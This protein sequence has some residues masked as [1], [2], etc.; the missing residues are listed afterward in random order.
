M[1][2]KILT[3]IKWLCLSVILALG[4]QS[5]NAQIASLES[6]G[7]FTGNSVTLNNYHNTLPGVTSTRFLTSLTPAQIAASDVIYLYMPTT[8]YSAAQKTAYATHIAAGKPLVVLGDAA[9]GGSVGPINDL[10]AALGS[11]MTVNNDGLFGGCQT[12]SPATIDQNVCITSGVA[13]VDLGFASSVNPG[14]GTP[15]ISSGATVLA[16]TENNIYLFGD[17]DF[18]SGCFDSDNPIMADNI[19]FG[20][21]GPPPTGNETCATALPLNCGVSVT[22]NTV[23]VAG[24]TQGFCGTS[25]GTGGGLWYT[26]TGDGTCVELTTC[27][28]FT[29]YDTKIRVFEG[30][31]AGLICVTG[32]DDFGDCAFSFLRSRVSFEAELGV[33]YFVLVHGF[34]S[35]EGNFQLD[36]ACTPLEPLTVTCPPGENLACGTPIPA[37][38]TTEA[39]FIAAG[40]TISG[41]S[42]DPSTYTVTVM[43]VL[44]GNACAGLTMTRTY[45]VTNDNSGQSETCIQVIN[46]AAPGAPSIV[47]PADIIV[48]CEDEI[49]LDP[50]DAVVTTSCGLGFT[51]YI[52]NPLQAGV[53]GCDGTVYTYIYKVVDDCG[54]TN[55]CEQQVLIQNAPATITVP[56]GGTVDCFEDISISLGQ[57]SVSGACAEYNLYLESPVVGGEMGCPG[58]T[59]TYTYRL[60]DQCGNTVEEDV[61]FTQANN[62]E[63][64]ITSIQPTLT[65]T[66][67]A[68]VNPSE[69][70][71]TYDVSCGTEGTVNIAGPQII[72][73]MDCNGT[74]YRYTYTVTDNCGRTSIGVTLDYVVQNDGPVFAGCEDEQWLQFNCED[75][76]GEEG[77]IAAIEAYIASV[78][79]TS[80]CGNDLTVFN[81]FNS[82]NINTCI[83]NGINTI[84]FRATDNC[85]RTSFCTT[86]YVVVDTEAPVVFEDAQ[87]HWEICN[88][89]SPHNFDDWV[90]N[91]GGAGAYDGCSTTNV[92]WS[93]IPSN[94]SFNCDGAAGVTSTTVTFVARDNC[95]NTSST[96]ATFNAFMSNSDL[97]DHAADLELGVDESATMTLLQNRPNPF[98]NETLIGFNLPEATEATLTIYDLNGRILKVFNGD[99]AQGLNE[100][101]V[102][103]SE[104]GGTGVLYYT[105]RTQN[106][107]AT[108]VMVI[109]D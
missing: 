96:T 97:D 91:H 20:C 68:G 61:V 105:L 7:A 64:I 99:Y 67:L 29:D 78:S 56:A 30:S 65:T 63:P 87:D 3:N 28:A 55:E 25:D 49:A 38:H 100:V 106:E 53:A 84:T 90:D 93:T 11:S 75:Y 59:Y 104:L 42:C 31:C 24:D 95:G 37:P 108:K 102:N 39:A 86:T 19:L 36:I 83:N 26:F 82:N 66:C 50:N 44:D 40:G 76:G 32:N 4:F 58:T 15:F 8:N 51:V 47:C 10:M 27:N 103:R 80:A 101:K 6:A 22:G 77:T 73:A 18:H 57:A 16:A 79:A 1:K 17:S 107:T 14:A 45:T 89:D 12:L 54:R 85:G 72:G 34:A 9:S 5:T 98:S 94:P 23:G 60:I 62:N 71:I 2:N 33:E 13:V 48:A 35:A 52:K 21:S 43:G 41:G 70:Y 109:I 69:D 81:N 88:Y 46:V 74:R 92:F